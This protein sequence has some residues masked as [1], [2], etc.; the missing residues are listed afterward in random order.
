M[1]QSTV[2]AAKRDSVTDAN[3][4]AP[5]L[6]L[7]LLLELKT[8][9]ASFGCAPAFRAKALAPEEERIHQTRFLKGKG[10]KGK[11]GIGDT[12]MMRLGF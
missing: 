5:T 8:C 7:L 2:H 3:V 11:K 9:G 6:L 1:P 12:R 4:A 10:K